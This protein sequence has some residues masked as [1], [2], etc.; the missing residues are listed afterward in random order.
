MLRA[1]FIALSTNK[2]LRAFAE[3][4]SVGRR[5]TRRFVAG[6]TVEE[7]V[8]AVQELNDDGIAATLDSLGES[9]LQVSQAEESAAV[10][11]RLLDE[12]AAHQLNANISLKLSQM[13]LDIEGPGA[14]PE[15]AERL[16]GELVDH[17]AETKNSI[18][19]DMEG[20]PLLLA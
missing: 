14:G 15:L 11:H 19:L 20:S 10:Y 9:V 2:A 4:S 17:A 8:A 6:V 1:F 12:I 3:R 5:I 18:R 7:A 16:V 13:G